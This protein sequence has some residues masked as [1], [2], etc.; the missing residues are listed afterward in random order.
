MKSLNKDVLMVQQEEEDAFGQ[1]DRKCFPFQ[2]QRGALGAPFSKKQIEGGKRS[3]QG[4]KRQR[5][6]S[7]QNKNTTETRYTTRPK[8][9]EHTVQ[10]Q[11]YMV[12]A[13]RNKVYLLK[14]NFEV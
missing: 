4:S 1:I 11:F 5:E 13:E 8:I 9:Y 14:Y 7:Q 6:V 10:E 12:W 2:R 3:I